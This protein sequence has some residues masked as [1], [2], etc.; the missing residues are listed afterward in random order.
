M[1]FFVSKIIFMKTSRLKLLFILTIS[2]S[3]SGYLFFTNTNK[4]EEIKISE[5]KKLVL[6]NVEALAYSESGGGS[7]VCIGNGSIDCFG[8]KVA[9]MYSG[10]SL[11]GF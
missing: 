8:D 4:K 9:Y 5:F 6:A 7:T 1:T 3:L 11:D 2:V 10:F